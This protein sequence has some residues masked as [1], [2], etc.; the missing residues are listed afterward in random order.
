[1]LQFEFGIE[2]IIISEICLKI[3]INQDE[4]DAWTSHET[5]ICC[6]VIM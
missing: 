2:Y 6:S 1:M 3:N 4:R 5:T